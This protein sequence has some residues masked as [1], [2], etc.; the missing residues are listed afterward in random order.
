MACTLHVLLPWDCS[1]ARRCQLATALLHP[2]LF[3]TFLS[4]EQ[5]SFLI[6]SMFCV[7]L[8][9]GLVLVVSVQ[10]HSSCLRVFNTC[11][12]QL[13]VDFAV[14]LSACSP[15]SLNDSSHILKWSIL[16]MTGFHTQTDRICN[17]FCSFSTFFHALHLSYSD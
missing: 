3:V 1:L 9:H 13:V 14:L 6:S 15:T 10:G 8:L 5:A 11:F 2:S 17:S 4:V 7:H 16:S 12:Y